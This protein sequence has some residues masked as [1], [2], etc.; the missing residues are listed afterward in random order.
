MNEFNVENQFP[1]VITPK[2]SGYSYQGF[3]QSL[4]NNQAKLQRLLLQH[5][6]LLLRGFPIDNAANF[7]HTIEALDLGQFVNY[8]GGDSPRDKVEEKIYTSTE[9]P[10]SLHIPLHQELSFIKNFPRHI[11]FFCETAP[12]VRG[13]TIIGDARRIYKALNPVIR[14]QFE[15]KG[16]TYTS[17]YYYQSKIMELLNRLQRSHKSWREV[18]ETDNKV[19]VQKKCLANE[20][21]WRW[22]DQDW[23]EIKQTRPAILHHPDTHEKV[24]FNQAHLYDFNPR[25]L[26]W[27][28][29]IG[30][31]LFY[32][33][34]STRL[35]EIEYGD[36]S[37]I[38]RKDLYH[39][40]DVLEENTVAF[41]WQ[42][43]D[44]MVLDNILTMHGRAPFSG[45]RRILTALT[46]PVRNDTQ[47]VKTQNKEKE[48]NLQPD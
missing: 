31:K 46:S 45:K 40:L 16:L 33:R 47:D 30:A 17:H 39:I 3:L 32:F 9:A 42:K 23:L 13:E 7:A 25:L 48:H 19:E 26:G 18:F 8:I 37:G 15:E 38:A 1:L 36:E 20:F 2:N 14:D 6:A 21:D 43:N 29:Y 24:W 4:R 34:K 44:V 12:E 10:P 35:H 5:G 11:Y 41:P 28:K 22:L 27:K